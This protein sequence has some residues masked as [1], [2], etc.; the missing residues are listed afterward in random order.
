MSNTKTT[1]LVECSGHSSATHGLPFVVV[2][3]NGP[4]FISNKFKLF[5]QKNEIKHRTI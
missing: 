1:S 4:S 3:D 5:V 2:T